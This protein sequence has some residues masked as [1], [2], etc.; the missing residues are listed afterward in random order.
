MT[1]RLNG[2]F[3]KLIF[4]SLIFPPIYAVENLCPRT[5]DLNIPRVA[6]LSAFSYEGSLFR[7]QVNEKCDYVIN[8]I[9]FTTG[10]LQNKN[11][12]IALTNISIPNATMVA[13]LIL[14]KF[15]I[16]KII[17]SGIGGGVNTNLFMGDVIIP[18][19]W[20]LYQ[21][22]FFAHEI[23]SKPAAK[24]PQP[25]DVSAFGL[26]LSYIHDQPNKNFGMIYTLDT[27]VTNDTHPQYK[28]NSNGMCVLENH[29]C[30][31]PDGALNYK[32]WFEVDPTLLAVAQEIENKNLVLLKDCAPSPQ[33]Q[34]CV[35]HLHFGEKPRM[36]VGGNGVSGP[37]FVDNVQYREYIYSVYRVNADQERY[38]NT[39]NVLD[40]ETAAVAMVAYSN[41]RNGKPV[42]FLGVRAISCLVGA[43]H[44]SMAL[45][46]YMGLALENTAIVV[47]KILADPRV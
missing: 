44:T 39:V 26:K 43:D 16:S 21:E 7:Q 30:Y 40:M 8:G 35:S 24:F 31:V 9:K 1:I 23:D 27:M 36:V 46:T 34:V 28:P 38:H 17:Y 33:G 32:F 25:K 29:F 15:N 37:T 4:L 12:V 18:E 20:A 6:L 3:R 22:M 45:P 47:L 11:V 19:R 5:P 10:K 2:F 13:Q 42:P 41:S 14:D